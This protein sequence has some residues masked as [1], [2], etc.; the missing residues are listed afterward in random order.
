MNTVLDRNTIENVE[1]E[2][3]NAM[4]SE[5]YRK[6]LN[7]VEDQFSTPTVEEKAYAPTYVAEQTAYTAMPVAEQAPTVREFT[8]ASATLTV[9]RPVVEEMP[10]TNTFAPTYVAPV[11]PTAVT[12]VQ[13]ATQVHYSLTPLAKIAMAVFTF[14]VIAMLTLIAFNSYSIK[15]KNVKLKNLE[16]KKQELTER[17]EQIQ[18]Y[19]Q[20]LQTEESILERAAEAGLVG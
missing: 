6:L 20:E 3:H 8:P 9:E 4:I 10:Q 19:I 16:E 5:R 1:K 18:R 2:K 7:A 11:Q 12:N 14:V 15:Q 13:K 17:N